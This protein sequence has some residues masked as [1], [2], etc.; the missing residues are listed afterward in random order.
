MS[1]SPAPSIVSFQTRR[2]GSTDTICLGSSVLVGSETIP[3]R[4]YIVED[5]RCS[6]PSFIYRGR[7]KHIAVAARAAELDRATALPELF[8]LRGGLDPVAWEPVACLGCHCVEIGGKCHM[9]PTS[10]AESAE[11]RCPC[12]R[13]WTVRVNGV[14]YCGACAPLPR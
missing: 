11:P 13:P 1:T 2:I 3:S 8:L 4:W 6:C 14:H 9:P 5:G 12:G 7:C 10:A